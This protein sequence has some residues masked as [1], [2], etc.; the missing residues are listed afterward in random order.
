MSRTRHR[1]H[2]WC[3]ILAI[4]P[5]L[6]ITPQLHAQSIPLT[7]PQMVRS[8]GSIFLGSVSSVRGDV[9]RDGD[10]VTITTFRIEQSVRGS[11]ER[12]LTIRQ[13]G[14]IANGLDTRI[15]DVRYFQP[16]ERVIVL[17]Y[18]PSEIG[19]TSPIGMSQGAFDVIPVDRVSG[20]D[21][22]LLQGCESLALGRGIHADRPVGVSEFL[23]LLGDLAA[24]G[25]R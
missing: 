6:A 18:P 3:S 12:T 9:D 21:A 23:A 15:S 17:L 4:V 10:N 5:L 22:R 2:P 1:L 11:A 16:G 13:F 7:L 25:S 19:F 14:G 24:E 20:I 8:A